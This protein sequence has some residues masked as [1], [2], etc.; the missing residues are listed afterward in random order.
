[1]LGVMCGF[2]KEEA[3]GKNVS[4]Q[5]LEA[6]GGEGSRGILHLLIT[7]ALDGGDRVMEDRKND[8]NGENCTIRLS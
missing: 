7:S 4:V 2:K 6:K 5:A 1:M 3:K 8:C